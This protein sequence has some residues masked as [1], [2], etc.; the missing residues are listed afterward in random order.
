LRKRNKD[1][2][3]S[4]LSKLKNIYKVELVAMDMWR[5]YKDA[6]NMVSPELS[7]SFTLLN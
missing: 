7:T 4:H 5:P 3:I 6:V 2:V 1:V